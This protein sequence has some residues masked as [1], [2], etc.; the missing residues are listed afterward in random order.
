[1]LCDLEKDNKTELLFQSNGEGA[2]RARERETSWQLER[3][4]SQMFM[5]T[6]ALQ[7]LTLSELGD[8]CEDE[9]TGTCKE[10]A[11]GGWCCELS[12]KEGNIIGIGNKG[13]ESEGR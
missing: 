3:Y 6:Y 8:T 2:Q 13:G 7:R 10:V 5:Q 11:I 4:L 12:G 9:I 1:M